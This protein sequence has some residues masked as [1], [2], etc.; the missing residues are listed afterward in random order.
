MSTTKRI[1]FAVVAVA[2]VI[3]GAVAYSLA[4]SNKTSAPEAD[5]HNNTN[6]QTNDQSIAS[7]ITYDGS[8]FN[9]SAATINA[10]STVKVVNSS[11]DALAFDSDPH[12]THT[13]NPELNEGDIA[14]GDS[15]TFV[16]EKKGTWGFHN[17]LDPSQHGSIKVE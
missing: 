8:S 17:H 9:V 12:P 10:G 3:A 15:R 11:S 7:T 1:I 2:A 6:Q 16:I 14:P 5:Q 4:V 13:D